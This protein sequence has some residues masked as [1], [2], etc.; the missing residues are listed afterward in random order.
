MVIY[1]NRVLEIEKHMSA[2]LSE[3]DIT[4][5]NQNALTFINYKDIFLDEK[6]CEVKLKHKHQSLDLGGIA[7]GY[8]ADAVS[9]CLFVQGMSIE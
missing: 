1:R 6:K 7:K 9:T 3:S 5:I 8:A 2:F 4:R